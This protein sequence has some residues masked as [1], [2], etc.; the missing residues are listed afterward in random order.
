MPPI[1]TLHQYKVLELLSQRL[2][3]TLKDIA[4]TLQVSKSAASKCV[5]RL[6]KQGVIQKETHTDNR[7][8]IN[9]HITQD[10]KEAMNFM[11]AQVFL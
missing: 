1:L 7:Q 6:E 3:W 8:Y 10:G 11:A 4:E 2:Q 5:K 9:I